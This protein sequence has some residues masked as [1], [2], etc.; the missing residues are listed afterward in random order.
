MAEQ[1]AG[2]YKERTFAAF[3]SAIRNVV[4][5]SPEVASLIADNLQAELDTLESE[6][7]RAAVRNAIEALRAIW[8]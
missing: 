4:T 2:E 1:G 3:E 6:D 8:K 7:R 5:T